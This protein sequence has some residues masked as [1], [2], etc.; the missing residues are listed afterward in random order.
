MRWLFTA[1][2]AA[3]LAFATYWSLRLAAADHYVRRNTLDDQAAA[4]RLDPHN[5]EQRA[6]LAEHQAAAG[7]DPKPSLEA[8]ARLNPRDSSIPIRLGLRAEFE[9]DFARAERHLLEAARV[10]RLFDPRSTLMN[11]YFR[12]ARGD[13]FWHWAR[14]AFAVGYGDR[15]PLFRLCWRMT[16]DADL[17]AGVL[18]A[19]LSVRLEYLRFLLA[20]RRLAAAE[21]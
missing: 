11:F 4:V 17:I 3:A 20:E 7:L 8:A 1:P 19:Q 13:A 5:A 16:T 9:G 15:A 2:L 12:R 18:P 6:R 10:D 14:E 21:P